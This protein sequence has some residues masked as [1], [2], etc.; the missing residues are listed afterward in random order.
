VHNNDIADFDLYDIFEIKYR[1]PLTR[2]INL[3]NNLILMLQ[4]SEGYYIPIDNIPLD[5]LGFFDYEERFSINGPLSLPLGGKK[6][7]N[8]KLSYLNLS[9]YNKI[10]NP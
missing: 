6:L 8:L 10:A 2:R 1:G 3:V 5:N 7:V 9:Y 4:D